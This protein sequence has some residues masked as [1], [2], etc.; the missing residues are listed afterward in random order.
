MCEPALA[1]WAAL[2][3]G[4]GA[5]V[6]QCCCWP[7]EA[8]VP[9]RTGRRRG[10]WHPH[11]CGAGTSRRGERDS[12]SAQ[13]AS[14]AGG[15]PRPRVDCERQGGVIITDTLQKSMQVQLD[16]TKYS[17]EQRRQHAETVNSAFTTLRQE[18][19]MLREQ[20]V[21]LVRLELARLQT[22]PLALP[23]GPPT[24]NAAGAASRPQHAVGA[25]TVKGSDPIQ[26]VSLYGSSCPAAF[27]IEAGLRAQNKAAADTRS[28]SE[29]MGLRSNGA[30]THTRTQSEPMAGAGNFGVGGDQI[31]EQR[32]QSLPTSSPYHTH[33]T[34][35]TESEGAAQNGYG[36]QNFIRGAFTHAMEKSVVT[37]A[38]VSRGVQKKSAAEEEREEDVEQAR[39]RAQRE[40]PN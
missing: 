18:V 7:R 11:R 15:D 31:G 13:P 25:A 26:N 38:I 28:Q 20:V 37:K 22:T 10:E 4:D 17:L 19:T 8:W 16:S 6:V 30:A 3:A 34:S 2:T 36:F 35:S 40:H 33:H 27:E 24:D 29:P 5:G 32:E 12:A 14:A 23:Q 9:G 39:R 1:T 21:E